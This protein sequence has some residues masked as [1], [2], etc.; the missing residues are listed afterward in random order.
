M[1]Y[2]LFASA[3]WEAAADP[4]LPEAYA[5][6]GF[7]HCSEA[8]QVEGIANEKYADVARLFVLE[9]DE[10]KLGSPVRREDLSE[11]GQGF[12]HIYGPIPH[13]AV[14]RFLP[15]LR[16]SDGLLRLPLGSVP[17][18]ASAVE[19][20]LRKARAEDA[21]V[22]GVFRYAMFRDMHPEN[23][24]SAIRDA[25]V[26]GSE[27]YYRRHASD[28][29]FCT[30]V[31]QAAEGLVGCASLLIEEKPPHAKRLRNVSGYVLTVYVDTAFRERGIARA[32]MEAIREEASTQGITRLSLHASRFGMPLYRS[33]GYLPNPNYLEL[34]LE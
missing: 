13:E 33:L 11:R 22:L 10:A 17:S 24:Y 31:A 28:P 29:Q 27:D 18:A 15:L 4:Y 32:L 6:D 26:S 14:V 8:D 12:P 19:L 7:I 20:H 21:A 2:H 30:F 3:D 16:G 23:D 34:E 9:I 5:R 25:L 1:I